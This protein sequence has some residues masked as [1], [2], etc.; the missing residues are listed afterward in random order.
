M[1]IPTRQIGNNR[2]SLSF[3]GGAKID[4]EGK[5]AI[6]GALNK[7]SLNYEIEGLD[8]ADSEITKLF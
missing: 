4:V 8:P 3:N 6:A 2:A 5:L 7:K 1:R